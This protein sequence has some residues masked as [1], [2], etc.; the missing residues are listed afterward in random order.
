MRRPLIIAATLFAALAA[1]LS[2]GAA[3]SAGTTM[4]TLFATQ[5]ES[6]EGEPVAVTGTML[7]VTNESQTHVTVHTVWKDVTAVGLLS[8]NR[9][10]ANQTDHTWIFQR[11]DGSFTVVLQQE[12]ELISLGPSPNLLVH[13]RVEFVLPPTGDDPEIRGEARCSGRTSAP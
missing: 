13:M 10:E 7:T 2:P 3:D 4:E 6:C 5:L 11:K 1:L 9:Y 8:A 12:L